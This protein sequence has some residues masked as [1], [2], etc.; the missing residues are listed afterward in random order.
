MQRSVQTVSIPVFQFGIFSQ[1]DLSFFPGPDF[2][3]GGRV[4][5]NGNLFL[6]S[7]STLTFAQKVTAV[8][9]IVRT[10]L[11]NGWSTVSNYTG[12]VDVPTAPGV[13]RPLAMTEGSLVGTLGSS[14]NS[15]WPKISHGDY[16]GYISN[17]TTGV[18]P[19]NLAITLNGASPIDLIRRPAQG[20]D[21][22]NPSALAQRYYSEASVRILISDNPADISNLPCSTSKIPPTN[23]ATLAPA[24]I[25]G[26]PLALSAA[27]PG[28][29][30]ANG[31]WTGGHTDYGLY[32]DRSANNLSRAAYALWNLARRHRRGTRVRHLWP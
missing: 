3:F 12:T 22:S 19:L 25:A 2:N 6:A 29:S 15:N 18:K 21:V 26:L 24:Q 1:I 5:T 17:S 11:S 30:S 20:E 14:Q 4:H 8:G 27:G 7:G 28:Y 13:Y 32:Q 10:N 16:N 9:E 31:Y 23:L